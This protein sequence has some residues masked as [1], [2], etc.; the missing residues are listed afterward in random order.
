[1][2]SLADSVN[3][4]QHVQRTVEWRLPELCDIPRVGREA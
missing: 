1:M 3:I 2:P 4:L